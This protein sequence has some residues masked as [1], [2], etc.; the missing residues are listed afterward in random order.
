MCRASCRPAP[1]T[2][3]AILLCVVYEADPGSCYMRCLCHGPDQA[4]RPTL[5]A[6]T[7]DLTFRAGLWAWFGPWIGPAPFMQSTKPGEF[8]ILD[9]KW[10]G[11]WEESHYWKHLLCGGSPFHSNGPRG[12]LGAG[13]T[14]AGTLFALFS[15]QWQLPPFWLLLFLLIQSHP[16]YNM[17][18]GLSQN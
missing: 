9:L 6:C 7:L 11:E 12:I 14:I 10:H 5:N 17:S 3:C 16:L 13:T 15:T 4:H 8:D 18:H 1:H 2:R